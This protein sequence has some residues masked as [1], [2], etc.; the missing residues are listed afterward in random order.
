M[1][2]G[3]QRRASGSGGGGGSRAGSV[4]APVVLL[5]SGAALWA[6]LQQG[7]SQGA[8]AGGGS[9]AELTAELGAAAAKVSQCTARAGDWGRR[10]DWIVR[11]GLPQSPFSSIE[12]RSIAHVRI[13]NTT[14]QVAIPALGALSSLAYLLLGSFLGGGSSSSSSH[15]EEKEAAAAA[16]LLQAKERALRRSGL[17]AR[18]VPPKRAR[19]AGETVIVVGAGTAGAA[20]AVGLAERGFKV[21]LFERVRALPG[22]ACCSLR[23]GAVVSPTRAGPLFLPIQD[24]SLQDRIVGEL[25]Q[26]GGVRA[27]ERLGL[28]D[29]AKE[30][31]DSVGVDGYVV[32]TPNK[33]KD[34]VGAWVRT[35]LFFLGVGVGVEEVKEVRAQRLID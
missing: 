5:G 29:C 20:A 18:R 8:A 4:V 30:G 2:S 17:G 32:F 23:T 10:L 9:S 33:G 35:C 25:L 22:P 6:A 12:D 24:M 11:V 26:P 21:L 19:S 3:G 13:P 14:R 15:K 34:E 7:P 1:G 28:D 16:G 27:L 31:I